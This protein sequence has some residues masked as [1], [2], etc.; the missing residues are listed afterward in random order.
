MTRNGDH[1]LQRTLLQAAWQHRFRPAIAR[2]GR[3]PVTHLGLML[4]TLA[5]ARG[6]AAYGDRLRSPVALRFPKGTDLV[7]HMLGVVFAG[8]TYVCLDRTA[9]RA[10]WLASSAERLRLAYL[11]MDD[12]LRR[13]LL[14]YTPVASYEESE[15]HSGI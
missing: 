5:R 11:N 10:K 8:G 7:E 12:G 13:L 6:L 1:P 4:R 14:R 15:V 3:R 2:P 9:G